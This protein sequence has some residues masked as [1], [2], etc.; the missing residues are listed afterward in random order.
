M[1]VSKTTNH[2]NVRWRATASLNGKRRQRFFTSREDARAWLDSIRT[3]HTGFWNGRTAEEQGEIVSAFKLAS[4][5]G[6]SLHECVLSNN[7]NGKPLPIADAINRYINVISQRSLRPS[8]L[9]QTRINLSQLAE[10]FAD[11]MCHEVSAGNLEQWFYKLKWK[12]STIDGVIAKIG[13]FFTWCMREGYRKN[14]PCGAV[15]RPQSDDVAPAIFSPEQAR[16]LLKTAYNN[17]V[18]LAPYLA[19]GLF[20]GVRPLEIERLQRSD[21]KQHHIE[22]SAAKSKTRKRRL[23]T[24]SDNLRKW[25]RVEGDLA[26]KNRRKRLSRI[27]EVAE[28]NWSPDIMRHSFASYHLA[29]HE[30]ADKTALEM[31][32]RDTQMLFRHYREI[33][34][35]GEAVEYWQTYP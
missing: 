18:G 16:K 33:V 5:R 26:P 28:L 8:S 30:S 13:P 4:E 14:N 2:G 12:R 1:R 34:T 9:K 27:L 32:H 31:G 20:A 7:I 24:L 29:L 10:E 6:L 11:R 25:L 15:R 22:V 17:D 23:I 35:K 19:L 21:I 3:D